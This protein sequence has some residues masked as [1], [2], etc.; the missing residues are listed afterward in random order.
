MNSVETKDNVQTVPPHLP[1]LPNWPV[2]C[3][4]QRNVG[5][6]RNKNS[7]VVIYS[8]L[9]SGRQESYKR[10]NHLQLT[11]KKPVCLLLLHKL[12]SEER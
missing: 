6:Q 7:G 9:N 10:L 11:K 3:T 1:H 12:L 8:Q 4:S 2:I 5:A